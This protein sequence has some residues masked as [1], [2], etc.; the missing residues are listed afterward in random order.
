[1]KDLYPLKFQPILK[2][3]IWGGKKLKT[4]FN[5]KSDLNNVGESWEISDV[6]GDTSIVANGSLKGK[7]LKQLLITS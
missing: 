1:M 3:K 6:D 7:S 5:K 2:D 4:Q